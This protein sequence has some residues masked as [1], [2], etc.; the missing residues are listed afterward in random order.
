MKRV[1]PGWL[2]GALA[3]V[4]SCQTLIACAPQTATASGDLESLCE[5]SGRLQDV[6]RYDGSFGVP[7]AFVNRHRL[8]VGLLR[9][10][11]DLAERYREQAGNVNG[12]G[13][14]TGTLIDDDLF[15]TAG[16]CLD[17]S[18]T[19]VWQ[20]PR[21]KGGV[22]LRPAELARE[23]VVQF[24]YEASAE[25]DAPSHPDSAEVLRL[26]EYRLGGLDYA[27]LRLSDQP[28][29][30]NGTTRISARD[31]Q[32]GARIAILQHPAAAT[33]KV[34]AGTVARVQG[35]TL[36]YDTIDTLG[37]SSGAGILD[38]ETGKLVGVHTT[39]GCT[40][41][42]GENAGVTIGALTAASEILP[43]LVDRS[44]DLL[45]GDWDND[46]LSD[47]AVFHAGCLYPDANHDGAPDAGLR[48]CPVEANASPYFIGNWEPGR[49]SGLGWRRGNCVY[50][51]VKPE[52]PLCFDPPFE[53]LVADWNDD[54]RSDLGVRRGSCID[55]D[56]NLDGTLDEQGYCY[57]D[58]A[59]EDEYLVG[60]WDGGPRPSVAVRRGSAVLVDADRDGRA[61]EN[62]RA[63]GNGGAEHQYLVG[64]WDGDRRTDLAVRRSTVCMLTHDP[65]TGLADERRE[66]RDFWSEP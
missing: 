32:P 4:L 39:G 23:L 31:A 46:G 40:K 27:I 3:S 60:T 41:S 48:H 44:Q 33:M 62:P 63:Y 47:L 19:G 36:T 22:E 15:L 16:H 59:A 10:R 51:D 2:C 53:I 55:F 61:D 1:C 66:Y 7:T 28:G 12:Q 25:S 54:G 9:W 49:A 45:V 11:S 17:P 64:D 20:L 65:A 56:T 50:L 21:E 5:R 30:R 14:C 52:Q 42:G 29:V 18:D 35:S 13:W 34:G 24:R 8:A 43:G 6:E 58:G 38:A 57:G 26:E 37:G